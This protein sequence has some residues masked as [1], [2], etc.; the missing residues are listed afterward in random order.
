LGEKEVLVGWPVAEDAAGPYDDGLAHNFLQFF[1]VNLK[2]YVHKHG[3][4]QLAPNAART[5]REAGRKRL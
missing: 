1:V 3:V 5:R 2:L 4:S